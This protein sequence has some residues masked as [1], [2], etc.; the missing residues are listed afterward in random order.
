MPRDVS[1]NYSLPSEYLAVD[2]ETI[3][4]SQH[5]TPLV[6]L[7]TGVTQSLARNG[8]GGMLADLPM[9]NHKIT[10][11][12]A[13]AASDEAVNKGQLDAAVAGV[14]PLAS[15]TF[16]GTPAAPTAALGTNTTQLATT[17]FVKSAVD[18]S[19]LGFT[20]I[21]QGGG[22]GQLGNKI[23]IGYSGSG[24][25]KAQVD[26]TDI[27]E[28]YTSTTDGSGSGLDADLLD[29]KHASE[30]AV[31]NNQTTP[32]VLDYPIGCT[33]FVA[34][35]ASARNANVDVYYVTAGGVAYQ[36]GSGTAKLNGTWRSCGSVNAGGTFVT[37]A[38]RVA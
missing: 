9:N 20:P 31:A 34:G 22:S 6:D 7:A 8:V 5:N 38:Q 30:F 37:V 23:Y 24:R 29:G 19:A 21:Q 2:G 3:L 25:L 17:A 14:A 28:L 1:G 27:G 10:M 18:A 11:L 35:S 26:N 32:D 36:I 16:T 4:P 33:L 15:P 13:G 12:T